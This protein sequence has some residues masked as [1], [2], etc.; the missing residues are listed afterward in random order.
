MILIDTGWHRVIRCLIFIGHFPQKSPIISGSCANNDLQLKAS[1][2]SL[3]PC[4]YIRY[5]SN[6]FALQFTVFT[7]FTVFTV[8][9]LFTLFTL[10]THFAFLLY[11]LDS[12]YS[13]YFL[14][15]FTLFNLFILFTRFAFLLS[16]LS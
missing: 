16:L 3:P 7:L 8:F 13:H 5:I 6:D 15:F 1:Y 9:N 10:F 12:L 2:E 4:R 14:T 11:C